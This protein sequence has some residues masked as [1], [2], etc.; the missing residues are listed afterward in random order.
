MV[1][2]TLHYFSCG[3]TVISLLKIC[4]ANLIEYNFK[5][6]TNISIKRKIQLSRAFILFQ[7]TNQTISKTFAVRN[8]II[9][10]VLIQFINNLLWKLHSK[11]IEVQNRSHRNFQT[12]IL[13][14]SCFTNDFSILGRTFWISITTGCPDL[15]YTFIVIKNLIIF[16]FT[17]SFF[18]QIFSVYTGIITRH[19]CSFQH[20]I[21]V[22]Y[23]K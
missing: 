15:F 11:Y 7:L 3:I 13:F 20:C 1:G 8:N 5:L 2:P 4:C 19:N 12:L 16:F 6:L 9:I 10:N 22:V 14:R 17:H 18:S 23:R 21:I